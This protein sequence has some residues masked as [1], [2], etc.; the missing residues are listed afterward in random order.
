VYLDYQE[1][2]GLSEY[3]YDAA[4]A[5]IAKPEWAPD[6]DVLETMMYVF[7]DEEAGREEW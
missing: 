4:H 1:F 5:S 6:G 3:W 2:S 7:D